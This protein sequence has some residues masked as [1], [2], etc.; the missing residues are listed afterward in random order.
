[1]KMLAISIVFSLIIIG[2]T[3]QRPPTNLKY[4]KIVN[5]GSAYDVLFS[6]DVNIETLFKKK[7]G[8]AAVSKRL[9]CA[10]GEDNNI[11]VRHQMK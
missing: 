7:K 8:E 3:D 1:M 9:L 5:M 11:E 6:S 10:L 4:Q 2:C